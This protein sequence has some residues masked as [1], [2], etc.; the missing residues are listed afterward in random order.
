MQDTLT[1][2]DLNWDEI[3]NNVH[4]TLDGEIRPATWEEMADAIEAAHPDDDLPMGVVETATEAGFLNRKGGG[5]EDSY[6][7]N[8]DTFEDEETDDDIH[9][10]E[11]GRKYAPSMVARDAWVVR[12]M[13]G[14]D[15]R[16]PWVRGNL[17][18]VKWGFQLDDDDRPD[19]DFATALEWS[20]TALEAGLETHE[21]ENIEAV[22]PSFIL[23]R[24]ADDPQTNIVMVD[25]DDVRNPETGEIHPLALRI[26][27]DLGSYTEIST[28]G[29]GVHVFVFGT[30]PDW[31]SGAD[32]CEDI[33]D[34]PFIG[35]ENPGLEI[36]ERRRHCVTTGHHL[37][38]SPDDLQ[39]R[40]EIID[41]LVREFMEEQSVEDLM[42]TLGD[43]EEFEFSHD[44][45]R[46]DD[47]EDMSAYYT[48]DITSYMTLTSPTFRKTGGQLQG[49]HPVHGSSNGSTYA[50]GGVNFTARREV[51]YCHSKGHDSGGN[52]LSLC[53][54]DLGYLDCCKADASLSNLDDVDFARVCLEFRD[55]GAVSSDERPPY[56]ALLGVAKAQKLASESDEQF[57]Y[58]LREVLE[59]MYDGVSAEML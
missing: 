27:D 58:G 49:P 47:R 4:D 10:T 18:R 52:A 13:P 31:Y 22:S 7:F 48:Q 14:K 40:H 26:I 43:E 41:D 45:T 57:D 50:D 21:D 23:G 17:K 19:T 33:D 35:D 37:E 20:E 44:T 38:D 9:S 30:L 3:K 34:E 12:T 25:L 15:I 55:S 39:N 6:T 51:W 11:D 36:Y 54:V 56:R 16:A 28:S 29:K 5:L 32:F 24:N 42:D 53:A 59:D 1:T 2:A 8:L 46:D